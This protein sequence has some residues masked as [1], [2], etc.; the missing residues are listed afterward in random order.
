M[1]LTSNNEFKMLNENHIFEALGLTNTNEEELTQFFSGDINEY[2]KHTVFVDNKQK[3]SEGKIS[4]SIL[5]QNEKGNRQ[6]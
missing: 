5:E 3:T 6:E 4:E 1:I 2:L